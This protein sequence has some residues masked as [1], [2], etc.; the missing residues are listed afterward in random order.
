MEMTIN[1]IKP[2][3]PK[4]LTA[5][6][7]RRIPTSVVWTLTGLV[8]AGAAAAAI[9]ASPVPLMLMMRSPL[10]DVVPTA[11]TGTDGDDVL[12]GQDVDPLERI[13]SLRITLMKHLRPWR[14]RYN[15]WWPRRKLVRLLI[16]K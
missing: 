11:I 10:N 1:L 5:I 4:R 7:P 13:Y 14:R 15:R 12:N 6:T 3:D 8:L 2:L 9:I 16:I